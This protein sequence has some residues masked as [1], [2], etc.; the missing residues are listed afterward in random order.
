MRTESRSL[1]VLNGHGLV[2]D[3]LNTVQAGWAH[4][5]LVGAYVSVPTVIR[6]RLPIGQF[7][8]N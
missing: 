1:T 6:Y 2:F 8:K 4:W 7:V 5:A 3:E